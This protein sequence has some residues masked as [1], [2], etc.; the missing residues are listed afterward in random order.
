MKT[1]AKK[2]LVFGLIS[3]FAF[4]FLMNF[5]SAAES[6]YDTLKEWAS[7]VGQSWQ[8]GNVNEGVVKA[9]FFFIVFAMVYT[10]SS[11]IP[12]LS[13]MY[14]N[15][16]RPF[17]NFLGYGFSAVIAFLSLWAI[18]PAEVAAIMISYSA[19]GYTLASVI[20]L[21]ILVFFT[22]SLAEDTNKPVNE[23]LAEKWLAAIMWIG[24]TLFST[25]R[26]FVAWGSA[27]VAF[28]ITILFP[29]A[30]I[31][32]IVS[33]NNVFQWVRKEKREETI[34]GA[35]DTH[36]RADAAVKRLAESEEFIGG[37][38]I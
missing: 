36:R 20:P 32:M 24:F 11:R 4:A 15:N 34:R 22:L 16:N 35:R 12:G 9:L 10:V 5:V 38:G 27:E 8:E 17:M 26:M 21:I 28:W 3:L 31:I 29:I 1:T 37:G 33:L 6:P 19:L 2:V 30:G 23:R 13:G 25:Y 7:S 14:R 18:N